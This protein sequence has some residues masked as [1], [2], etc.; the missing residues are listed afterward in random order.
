MEAIL[1]VGGRGTRLLPLTLKTPKPMLKVAG[2]PFIAHQI[3]YARSHGITRIIVAISYKTEQ[4]LDYLGDGSTFG[5]EIVHAIEN[6][7]MGTGGAIANASTFLESANDEAVAIMNGDVLSAHDI[8]AQ[9]AL[10]RA[11]KADA[12][13]HLTHVA[14]ARAYGSVPTDQQGRI[15]AFVEKSDAPPTQFINAGCYIFQRNVIDQI[16]KGKVVS[17]ERETFPNLLAHDARLW[18]YKS[19]RYWLDIGTPSALLKA[20]IDLVTG[21]FHS[22]A[23]LPSP[24]RLCIDREAHIAQGAVINPGS[25]IGRSQIEDAVAITESVIGDG[26]IIERGA[27]VVRS[28]IG[29]GVFVGAGAHLSGALVAGNGVTV[30]ANSRQIGE[31]RENFSSS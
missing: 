29:D 9:V 17:V 1:L 14:D 18:G 24:S 26:V 15:L 10:H 25:V 16:P 22:P 19:D 4:F 13:L 3:S 20:S 5:V 7:P 12:T 2:V 6:E 23:F 8:S 27:Q 31:I 28:I 11:Q 30:P 21:I